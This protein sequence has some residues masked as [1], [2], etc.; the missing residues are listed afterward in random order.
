VT[1]AQNF[2][3]SEFYLEQNDPNPF[4][5]TTKIKL[6]L[7]F[8]SK[9]TVLITSPHGKI[10]DKLISNTLRAGIYEI[11]FYAEGLMRGTYYYHILADKF[12]ETREME[13][14]K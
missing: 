4:N 8:E 7:P 14:I 6:S 12:S 2:G 13:L 1:N 5:G 11:E 9:V 3:K 10:I